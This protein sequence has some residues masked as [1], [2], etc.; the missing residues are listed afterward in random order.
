[1]KVFLDSLIS[2]T[3]TYVLGCVLVNIV[4]LLWDKADNYRVG[5]RRTFNYCFATFLM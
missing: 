3:I 2:T 4:E 1:M 5:D